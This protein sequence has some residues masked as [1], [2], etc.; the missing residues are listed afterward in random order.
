VDKKFRSNV[1]PKKFGKG[2]NERPDWKCICGHDNRRYYAQCPWCGVP[3]E[4][5][6]EAQKDD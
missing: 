3:Y 4:L 6:M 5:A 2:G 1:T